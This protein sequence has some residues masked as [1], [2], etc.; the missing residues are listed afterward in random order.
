[1]GNKSASSSHQLLRPGALVLAVLALLAFHGEAFSMQQSH[2]GASG[3]ADAVTFTR[4]VAPILQENCQICHRP[5][6]VGPMS[7]LNYQQVRHFARQI[8]DKVAAREMPPYH[9]DTGVGIQAIKNDWRLSEQEIGT[10]VAWVDTGTAERATR[11][12]CHPLWN[13]RTARS[14]SSKTG[15]A[16]R[17]T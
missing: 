9:L 2:D 13:G 16:N 17:I 12:T 15:W 10:I 8:K 5:G 4:D 1:M 7:L 6:S 11:R 14:G 3:G